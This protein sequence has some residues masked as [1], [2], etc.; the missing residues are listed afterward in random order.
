MSP[1]NKQ[2]LEKIR[3]ERREQ[4]K[5][6][7]LRLFA[8]RGFGGTK[9]SLIAAEAGISEGL[10]Y[11]YFS[12]KDELFTELVEEL[13]N[14]AS[15]AVQSI[16]QLLGTPYEQISALTQ[17]M[18]D[19]NNQYA[20]MFIQQARYSDNIPEKASQ[21]LQQLSGNAIIEKLLPVFVKGQEAGEFAA[22]NPREMLSWYFMIVHSL[23]LQAKGDEEFGLPPAKVLMRV[24]TD[25]ASKA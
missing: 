3:D 17:D 18:M 2:Q 1:L 7:A 22:G 21:I 25:G 16:H 19:E 8:R 15:Q 12:S 6:A 11:R 13:M 10:I 20:F 4:I 23:I 24:L 14:E 9:T 5:Q